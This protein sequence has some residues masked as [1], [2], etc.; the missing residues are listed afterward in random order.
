MERVSTLVSQSV[1]VFSAH[2]LQFPLFISNKLLSS[3]HSI[4]RNSVQFIGTFGTVA[5]ASSQLQT[6]LTQQVTLCSVTVELRATGP[7]LL[8]CV[9]AQRQDIALKKEKYSST[10]SQPWH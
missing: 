10:H 5:V 8:G 3:S 2:L 9:C 4:I 1:F 6:A 7:D